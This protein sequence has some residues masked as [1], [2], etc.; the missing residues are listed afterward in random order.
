MTS[1]V[2]PVFE[3]DGG[4]NAPK[5]PTASVDLG[6]LLF[7]DNIKYPPKDREDLSSTDFMQA[8]MTLERVARM[9]PVLIVDATLETGS[10]TI[11]SVTCVSDAVT[12][13]NVTI[14]ELGTGNFRITIPSGKLPTATSLPKFDIINSSGG[15]CKVELSSHTAT[16]FVALAYDYTGSVTGNSV[17][18][19]LSVY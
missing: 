6:G 15:V 4:G 17:A 8:T 10:S 5:R 7:T 1:P 2:Y 18:V 3:G 19:K 12:T 9:I 11:D 16:Q 14:A 13:S